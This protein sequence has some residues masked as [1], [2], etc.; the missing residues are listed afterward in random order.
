MFDQGLQ[1]VLGI[2]I[3]RICFER[4]FERVEHRLEQVVKITL[5]ALSDRFAWIVPTAAKIV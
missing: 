5:A 3:I 4:V 2:V 1:E